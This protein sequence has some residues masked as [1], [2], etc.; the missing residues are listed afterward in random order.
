MRNRLIKLPNPVPFSSWASIAGKWE[1][2]GPLRGK[3]DLVDITSRF[4]KKT[5]EKSESEMQRLALETA[6]KKKD[7]SPEIIDAVFAGDLINQCTSS[8][9]AM[10]NFQ[11]PYFGLYG[12]CST[13]VEG[14]VLAATMISTG[15]YKQCGVIS[16][17]HFCSAQRQFRFPLEYG[18]I[19]AP[20]SQRTVTGAG[21]FV[22][23]GEGVAQIT[24]VLPGIVVD[25]GVSDINNM[26]AGMAPAA[27]DT[28]A[29]YFRE[30]CVEPEEFCAIFTGDLGAEG[31]ALLIE[32]LLMRGIDIRKQHQDCGLMIFDKNRQD[33]SS[34]GS[35]CG[36]A[37]TTLAA[38]VLPRVIAGELKKILFIATGALMSPLSIHQG[39]DIPAIAHLVRIEGGQ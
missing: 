12:A 17:S 14:L 13:S 32:L 22:L 6:L 10:V 28:L 11:I 7:L 5:W 9:H 27:A 8:S 38:E 2:E 23:G 36:C 25:S 18:A 29:T 19:S 21:A 26:G 37:A 35:G 16:S 34:G 31:S 33:V 15:I 30:S 24:E 39:E 20:T 4:G 3:F 1:S